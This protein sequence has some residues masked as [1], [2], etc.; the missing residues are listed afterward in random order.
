MVFVFSQRFQNAKRESVKLD[1]LGTVSAMF[2]LA[3]KR[4][5]Y[6]LEEKKMREKWN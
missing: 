1:V 2:P 4:K 6:G 5:V 3:A